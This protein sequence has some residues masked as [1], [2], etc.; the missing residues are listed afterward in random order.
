MNYLED[1][2]AH[3]PSLLARWLSNKPVLCEDAHSRRVVGTVGEVQGPH[4]RHQA[5]EAAT[6]SLLGFRGPVGRTDTSDRK[7]AASGRC[8]VIL[9]A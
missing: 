6:D 4:L 7:K 1:R 5:Q 2:A 3:L 9:S 8:S